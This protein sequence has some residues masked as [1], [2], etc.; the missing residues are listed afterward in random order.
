MIEERQMSASE[1]RKDLLTS[2]I[3][4]AQEDE[5]TEKDRDGVR[6]RFTHQDVIGEL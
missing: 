5:N 3:R 1:D 6:T 2:L 4:A